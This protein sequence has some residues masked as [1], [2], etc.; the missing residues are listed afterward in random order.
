MIEIHNE[1]VPPKEARALIVRKGQHF[2]ITDL[3]G[4]QV[5]DVALFNAD[6]RREKLSLS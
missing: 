2:R 5:V 1:I 3:E 6:N 4:Q